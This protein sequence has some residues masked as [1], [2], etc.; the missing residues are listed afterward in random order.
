MTTPEGSQLATSKMN[1]ADAL[2]AFI[3]KSCP[4]VR[5]AT[6]SVSGG[7]LVKL[8]DPP[9]IEQVGI[10]FRSSRRWFHMAMPLN[11]VI[12]MDSTPPPDFQLNPWAMP[13]RAED[14]DYFLEIVS[15]VKKL[16]ELV[17]QGTLK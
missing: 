15:E 17:L 13:S 9:S 1:K 4:F 8:S 16:W 12:F 10:L 6:V 3:E 14:I 5:E 11:E 7:I 2:E